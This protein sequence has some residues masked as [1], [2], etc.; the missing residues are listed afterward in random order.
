MPPNAA[1]IVHGRAEGG[2]GARGNA[3]R[4]KPI[5]PVGSEA[6]NH[7]ASGAM[8]R[9]GGG[10]RAPGSERQPSFVRLPFDIADRVRSNCVPPR[11]A[12]ADG[13][14]PMYRKATGALSDRRSAQCS[15]IA[16]LLRLRDARALVFSASATPAFAAADAHGL[17]LRNRKFSQADFTIPAGKQADVY[18]GSLKAGTYEFHDEQHEAESKTALTVKQSAAQ[19]AWHS[20]WMGRHGREMARQLSQAGR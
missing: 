8:M 5:P 17:T 2:A 15:Q 7:A 4:A 6:V 19:H 3:T 20:I 10:G 18:I 16:T 11:P 14:H 1:C 13:V 12:A 9:A